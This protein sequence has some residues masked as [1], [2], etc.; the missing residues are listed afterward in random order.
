MM[1]GTSLGSGCPGVLGAP[2]LPA[3]LQAPG[4]GVPL[5]PPG[6][7][8]PRIPL[9]HSLSSWRVSAVRSFPLVG[10]FLT[11]LSKQPL[12]PFHSCL[13]TLLDSLHCLALISH[14]VMNVNI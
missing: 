4:P 8:F 3:A 12:P 13:L 9:P 7:L 5:L 1:T 11:F 6:A 14:Y 10:P 2:D